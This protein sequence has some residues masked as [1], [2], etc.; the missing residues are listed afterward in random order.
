MI[1]SGYPASAR[2]L[3]PADACPERSGTGIWLPVSARA[4]AWEPTWVCGR[5]N[6]IPRLLSWRTA[7]G[8]LRN[9]FRPPGPGGLSNGYSFPVAPG[10]RVPRPAW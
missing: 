6:M 7:V 4:A 9:S 3:L 10:L 5:V 1:I 8:P 2:S